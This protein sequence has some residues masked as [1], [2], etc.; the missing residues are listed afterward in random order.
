MTR[1]ILLAGSCAVAL[2]A[3]ALPA[4]P[5]ADA[6]PSLVW[7]GD[8]ES[9]PKLLGKKLVVEGRFSARLGRD[10]VAL[11]KTPVQFQLADEEVASRWPS[12]ARNVRLEG[13]LSRSGNQFV[14]TVRRVTQ[15]ASDADRHRTEASQLKDVKAAAWYALADRTERLARFYDDSELTRLAVEARQAGFRVEVAALREPQVAEL[16]QLAARAAKIG[17]PE[18]EARR[19]RHQAMRWRYNAR[20]RESADANAWQQVA[21]ELA[22]LLPGAQKPMK[23][24]DLQFAEE[25]RRRPYTLYDSTP[26]LRDVLERMLWCDAFGQRLRSEAAAPGGDLYKL[27]ELAGKQM[28]DVPAVWRDFLTRALEADARQLESLTPT[29]VRELA[30]AF[31]DRLGNAARADELLRTW[32]GGRRRALRPNDAEGRVRLARD[33]LADLR[34]DATAARLLADALAADSGQTAARE[35]LEQM[36]YRQTSNGWVK[37]APPPAAP[38]V[39]AVAV[40]GPPREGMSAE[41]VRQAMGGNPDRIARLGTAGGLIEQWVYKGPPAIYINLKVEGP[42]AKVVAVRTISR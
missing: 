21:D 32:L 16:L 30:G 8:L 20:Q 39:A 25:Y 31:R 41:Q 4:A 38:P 2:L 28:P 9:D 27:A 17:F 29:R 5:Q 24:D 40:S 11:K 6:D 13:T 15:V 37:N 33:Y 18:E 36:N 26:E 3:A 22:Q 7:I 34:D 42:A 12:S 10:R 1:F 23:S 35:L 14:F 19:L